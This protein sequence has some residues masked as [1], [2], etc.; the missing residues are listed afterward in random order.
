MLF[1]IS[2]LVNHNQIAINELTLVGKFARVSALSVWVSLKCFFVS[3]IEE[4]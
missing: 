2:S 1:P 4:I 3:K